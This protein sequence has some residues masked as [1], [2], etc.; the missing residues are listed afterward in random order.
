MK[1]LKVIV[2]EPGRQ[3]RSVY[4]SDTL[5]NLQANVGGYIET[6]T[7]DGGIVVI[8]D[9][10]GRLKGRPHCCTL[11][12]VDFVGTVILCGV[13]GDGFADLPITFAEAKHRFPS[14]WEG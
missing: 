7:L 6:V 1:K 2:K 13:E 9:E 14:L 12:G 8:C 5:E 3:P 4:I 11:G 10:E